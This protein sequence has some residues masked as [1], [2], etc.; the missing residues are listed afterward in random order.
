MDGWTA[1]IVASYLGIVVI[2]YE[3]GVI[4][5]AVLEFI[6]CAFY[7][8]ILIYLQAV[9]ARLTQKHDGEYLANVT[10][11]C[12][13]RFGLVEL[14]CMFVMSISHTEVILVALCMHE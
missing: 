6:R 14:V 11:D 12:L 4:Y 9:I 10:A 2:W 1:P 7:Y 13:K 3:K 5:R 8:L